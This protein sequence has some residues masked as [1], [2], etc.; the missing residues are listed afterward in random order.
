MFKKKNLSDQYREW[1]ELYG[2]TYGY[3][4]GHQPVFVTSDLDIIQDILI[5]QSSNF[6]ARKVNF[7]LFEKIVNQKII[8]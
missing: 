7:Y 1:T 2:K 8:I 3:F 4:E 5:K 6:A